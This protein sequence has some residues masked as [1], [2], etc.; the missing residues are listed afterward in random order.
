MARS[1]TPGWRRLPIGVELNPDGGAHARVWAPKR[2]Q[3]EVVTYDD[4]G[5]IVGATSLAREEGGYF[6]GELRNAAAETNY[7]FRLDGTD[8]FADPASRFQPEGPHG[9]SQIVDPTRF[10]WTDRTWQGITIEGQV[11]SEIHIGT[12][13]PTGTFRSA[14]EKL[15]LL[16]DAGITCIE[17]MPVNE[18]GGA[19]GWGYDGVNWYAPTHHY[20][21]P[22]DFRALVDAAHAR[23]LAVILDVVYNHLGPDGNYL[24]QYADTFMTKQATEWGEAIN[25]DGEGSEGVRELAIE[26]AG[27]WISEF[28]LDG[29]RL[30]ATQNIFDRSARHL[31]AEIVERARAA[32]GDRSIILIAENEPQNADLIREFG[33]DALW[34]D[35]FHHTAFVAMTG[36]NEAYL[37]GYRGRPQEFV[38][39]AKYGFLYQGQYFKWQKHRR[40]TATL[41]LTPKHFIAFLE[42]H[43]QVSN[44]A[45]SMRMHQLANP[46][47][48][49]ALKALLLL[50]PQ[51]PMLFQGEEFGATAPFPFFAGH[52]GELAEA[53]LKGRAEFLEQFPGVKA[54]G[55]ATMRDPADP[56]TMHVCR[57]DW[58]ERT[59]NA[60]TLAMHRDL[61]KLRKSDPVIAS[62]AGAI[63]G[64]LDG[65]VIDERTFVLRYF[66]RQHGDRLLVVN[67]GIGL[68]LHPAPEPLLAPPPGQRWRMKWSSECVEYGGYGTPSLD[69]EGR[70]WRIPAQSAVL[71]VAHG[72]Q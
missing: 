56:E 49:R 50:S 13:T 72:T 30:D 67:L 25:Y 14:I 37:S 42:S 36:N 51:T 2:R 3:V 58:E 15:D 18:F 40:G 57:L 21:S 47:M 44:L 62:Q 17:I 69:E 55:R 26:N 66:S 43:D 41:D 61:L 16:V 9:P 8:A 52:A 71:L 33:V 10:R 34:N 29:L 5:Q 68:E 48:C 23:G 70:G 4:G 28:R 63:N 7:K 1:R 38:S 45:R 20:G 46:A 6:S 39:A 11:I 53:V 12:F 31:I 24:P 59:T 27:Y 32:A 19:F 65:A 64:A 60:A 54:S 22:D 35:D